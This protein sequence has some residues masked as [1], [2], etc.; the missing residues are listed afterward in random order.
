[1]SHRAIRVAL[2][3]DWFLKYSAAQAQALAGLGADVVL[4]CREHS[5]EFN[6]DVQ[7][8]AAAI[9]A[10]QAAGVRV[11][12]L[13]GRLWEPTV[14]PALVRI[15]RSLRRFAPDLIH[16]H[17]GAD[18]R[19]LALL[20]R[21][22]IVLTIHDPSFHPGQPVAAL[23]PKRWFLHRA[24]TA[25]RR[26]ASLIVVH[27]E[28]L[29]KEVE[30]G[31][32][33]RCAVVAHGLHAH[34]EPLPAPAAP[35]VAF[36]GRLEPYKGLEVLAAAMPQV[37]AS[38]PDVQ[39]HVVGTGATDLPLRDP[40]VSF[41]RTYLPESGI[42]DLF[43]SA[44]LAVLPYTQASQTG[45][46]S[47]AVG[48]GVPVIATRVGG[49]PDLVLDETYLAQA[50]DHRGLAA[51]ILSHLDDGPEVRARVLAEVARPRSWTAGAEASLR[52]YEQLI[53]PR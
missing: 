32:G 41:E 21:V 10:A 5:F 22:P 12:E 16:A 52:L 2:V 13:P 4:L 24:R 29:R 37:W 42:E 33:Q 8:R 44:S 50:G 34:R 28:R 19:P 6:G 39:L 49:L 30:L 47:L 11:I 48:Y 26:R 17:D 14:L 40:R 46:G 7:E 51:A 45:A 38:R 36:F 15:S 31:E 20:P 43:R 27:S 1:M 23:A 53:D 18:P 3:C 25:W 35:A 9:H